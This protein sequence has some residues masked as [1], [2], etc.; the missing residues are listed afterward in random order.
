MTT[1][2]ALT[3]L[4]AV[5]I[6]LSVLGSPPLNTLVG[7]E[8]NAD[9]AMARN[10]LLEATR[11]VQGRGWHFNTEHD[12]PLARDLSGYVYLPSN[13]AR[14][15][16]SQAYASKYDVVVR[17]TRLY[18]RKNHTFVFTENLLAEVVVY[19]DFEEMPAYARNYVTILA[20]RRF[21]KRAVGSDALDQFTAD[22]EARALVLMTDSDADNADWNVFNNSELAFARYR[23][24]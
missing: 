17:G 20:A 11:E 16:L 18:D 15:D 7:A 22:D 13:I 10:I 1:P 8:T 9:V 5:N 23:L 12:Y 6:M 19:L 24:L 4:N 14:A 3:E 21:Q 2:A